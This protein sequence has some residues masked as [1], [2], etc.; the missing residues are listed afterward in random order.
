MQVRDLTRIHSTNVE[1]GGPDLVPLAE[2][3]HNWYVETTEGGALVE[4][5][6]RP[7]APIARLLPTCRLLLLRRCG[8]GAGRRAS[9]CCAGYR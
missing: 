3:Q 1:A 7:P 9:G 6:Q 4:A 8:I 5:E 2:N